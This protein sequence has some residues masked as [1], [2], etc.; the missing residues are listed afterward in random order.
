M[1]T[2]SLSVFPRDC[3][4]L[5]LFMLMRAILMTSPHSEGYLKNFAAD[6]SR[7]AYTYPRTKKR[8]HMANP[9]YHHPDMKYGKYCRK[10]QE[11]GMVRLHGFEGMAV[12]EGAMNPDAYAVISSDDSD[13]GNGALANA[14]AVLEAARKLLAE[15]GVDSAD[16]VA[17]ATAEAAVAS[18]EKALKAVKRGNGTFAKADA[19]VEGARKRLARLV[20]APCTEVDK[21]TAE[22]AVASAET[23][24]NALKECNEA[25]AKAQGTL[26]AARK[27]LAELGYGPGAD[28]VDKATA[29]AAEAT[30]E[31]AVAA[32]KA[33]DAL[34]RDYDDDDGEEALV[35]FHVGR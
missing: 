19:M 20:A 6:S 24:R 31:A 35:E 3:S 15:L 4:L 9:H 18:A 30:A 33:L 27:L 25:S 1:G 13:D 5:P 11:P 17:L 34:E 23:S 21:A 8:C 14:E 10:H 26:E 29:E 7:C 32:E 22:A 12:K 16:K 28:K 2:P